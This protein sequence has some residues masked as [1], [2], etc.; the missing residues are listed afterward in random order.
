MTGKPT[1]RTD[2]K[3]VDEYIAC[4]PAEARGVLERVRR[5]IRRPLPGAEERISYG[6]PAYRLHGRS[7]L[8]FAG[9]RE[10]YSLYPLTETLLAAFKDQLAQYELRGEGTIRFP[11]SDPVPVGLIEEIARLRAKEI[12]ERRSKA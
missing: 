5:A 4:Q 9:W 8:F 6:I 10:H 11:L 7:V 2:V 3:T 1:I 12:S